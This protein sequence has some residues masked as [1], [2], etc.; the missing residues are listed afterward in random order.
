MVTETKDRISRTTHL[1]DAVF[2]DNQTRN[3]SLALQLSLD[4]LSVAVLDDVLGRIL[5]LERFTFQSIQNFNILSRFIDQIVKQSAV[6]PY[7]YKK[8]NI[9][10]VCQKAT[11][12]PDSLYNS[13]K[14]TE[15]LSFN[16]KIEEEET[17][18]VDKLMNLD[19]KNI[20]AFSSSIK[21]IFSELYSNCTFEHYS[22]TLI[23][24]LLVL[25]KNSADKKM[26]VHVHA[27]SLELIVLKGKELLFYNTFTYK[28]AEDF[29]YYILFVCEQL[30]LNPENVAVELLGA[31]EAESEEY[32]VVFKYIRNV[33]FG[34]RPDTFN[35]G[36]NIGG[37]PKHHHFGLFSQFVYSSG[38]F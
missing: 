21:K 31:I 22:S 28:S 32:K 34:S 17:V 35:Y 27:S 14:A 4:G 2:D 30:Q 3:Y 7:P 9:A 38:L 12:V 33:K 1:V 6:L 20:F 25:N 13:D 37:L 19:S 26:M 10:I 29:I 15:L 5:A 8:V 11:L 16:H 24:T 36:M 18:A 23:E